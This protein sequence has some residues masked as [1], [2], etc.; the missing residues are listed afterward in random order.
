MV[1]NRKSELPDYDRCDEIDA[2]LTLFELDRDLAERVSRCDSMP[3]RHAYH[4]I[5]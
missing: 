3:H 1:R 5:I 4:E 2:P